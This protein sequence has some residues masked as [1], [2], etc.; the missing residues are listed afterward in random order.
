M[1]PDLVDRYV[2]RGRDADLRRP[3]REAGVKGDNGLTPG[4]PAQHRRRLVHAGHRHLAGRARLD[5]QHVPPDRR[6]DFNNRTSSRRRRSSRRT[7]SPAGRRAGRQEGRPVDWVGVADAQPGRARSIDF[8]NFFS[9]RGVLAAPV[10]PSEQAGAAAFGVS[11]QV[12]AFAPASGW[13]NVPAG[14]PAAPPQQTSL[15]RRDDV[16]RAEPEPDL[17]RLRLR[18]RRRRRRRL[19]PACSCVAPARQGRGARPSATSASATSGRDQADRGRRPDRRARRPDRRLLREADLASRPDLSPFKLYFTSVDAR[20]IARA[21]PCDAELREHARR[22]ASRPARPR[23]LRAARGRDH[24]RG[25]LRR[26]GRSSGPTST[27]PRSSTSSATVQP[28]TDLA[29]GRLPGHRRVLAPVPG[30]RPSRPTSTATRTRTTTTSTNDD[31]PDGRVAVREGYIRSAYHEADETLGLAPLDLMGGRRRRRSSPAPTTASRRSGTPSTRARCSSTLGLQEREQSSNCREAATIRRR[32]V[33]VT[34]ASRPAAPAARSRSTSTSARPRSG[35]GTYA[36]GAAANY[37]AVRNRS[38]TPSRTS[39]DPAN[40]GKQVVER[41]MH[42]EELRNVDGTRLA[43]PNRSGDVVVVLRPPYQF[44]A[45]TPGQLHRVLAVLRPARLP[46][47]PGRPRRTT[48]TCTARSWPPARASAS[49]GR[50]P[51]CAR[52]TSRRRSRSCWASPAR[53]TRA[54]GSCTT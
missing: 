5:E 35:T 6:A 49:T 24:R 15:T 43:H 53:R 2:G 18:Q 33:P 39:T 46:A 8:R 41:V 12:A 16:R 26:A 32:D 13:T 31:I 11:Y 21:A 45:A 50:S 3:D 37:D 47:G 19:R 22:P 30:P 27:G 1:R 23:R 36:A 28:D 48:S 34:P 38:S 25:H 29:D 17:R 40:P 7:P 44:D 51:A 9:T 10:D 42:K 14:D 4:L 54:A 20:A 52:S